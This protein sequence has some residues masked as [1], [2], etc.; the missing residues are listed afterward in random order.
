L[1]YW[2]ALGEAPRL[3]APLKL[4]PARIMDIFM[5]TSGG[6]NVL[7]VREPM[8]AKAMNGEEIKSVA[9][10]VDLV[11]K[12]LRAIVEEGAAKGFAFPVAQR[13]GEAVIP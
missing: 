8:I 5:D 11:R 6:A 3:C 7:K 4:D 2:E 13:A 12:D 10:D 9:F 1:V